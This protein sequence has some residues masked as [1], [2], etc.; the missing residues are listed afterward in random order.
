MC[1]IDSL[2]DQLNQIETY[3][4]N[5]NIPQITFDF[6]SGTSNFIGNPDE[7]KL[8]EQMANYDILEILRD[9]LQKKGYINL[10]IEKFT[11]IIPTT[12]FQI[13]D[14]RSIRRLII[15]GNENIAQIEVNRA[16]FVE[17]KYESGSYR[18]IWYYVEIKKNG[19][20]DVCSQDYLYHCIDVLKKLENY[21]LYKSC[22]I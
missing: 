18:G 5:H 16:N 8:Y 19:K 12:S 21:D 3:Y 10:S 22:S 17:K 4:E 1:S 2:I 13:P 11:R 20:L 9:L 14:V 15:Q 6:N 7:V